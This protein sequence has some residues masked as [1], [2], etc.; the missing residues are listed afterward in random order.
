MRICG[1]WRRHCVLPAVKSG[2]RWCFR[3]ADLDEWIRRQTPPRR[4]GRGGSFIASKPGEKTVAREP[5]LAAPAIRWW[6]VKNRLDRQ[7]AVWPSFRKI[8]CVIFCQLPGDRAESLVAPPIP[9]FR[10]PRHPPTPVAVSH[11]PT[12][13]K[14]SGGN[15]KVGFDC[16]FESNGSLPREVGI[17]K[18]VN[19]LDRDRRQEWFCT[20]WGR[21]RPPSPRPHSGG[22]SP[23]DPWCWQWP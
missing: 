3:R 8:Q 21:Y 20:L 16:L 2:D 6:P 15:A 12:S 14:A 4:G 17:V 7:R 10:P 23:Q 22:T 18:N 11:Y 13:A 1:A 5:T 9:A 19:K